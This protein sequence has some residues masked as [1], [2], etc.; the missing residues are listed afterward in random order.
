MREVRKTKKLYFLSQWAHFSIT[1]AVTDPSIIRAQVVILD[2]Q[3]LKFHTVF[4]WVAGKTVSSSHA[5]GFQI[6]S[7]NFNGDHVDEQNNAH[8]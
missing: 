1:T 6:R 8:F 7:L 3:T 4:S 2:I 5:L